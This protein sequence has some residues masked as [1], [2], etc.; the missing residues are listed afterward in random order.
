M[1]PT[2]VTV[3]VVAATLLGVGIGLDLGHPAFA[4]TPAVPAAPIVPA[5]AQCKGVRNLTPAQVT[6]DTEKW[7]DEQ[8]AA[9]RTHFAFPYIGLYCSW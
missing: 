5:H 6:G 3:L 9:G 2:H 1:K 8:I 7:L 4:D